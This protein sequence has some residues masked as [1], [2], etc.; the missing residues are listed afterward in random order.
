[1]EEVMSEEKKQEPE[2]PAEESDR[3][4]TPRHPDKP[5]PP[6]DNDAGIDITFRKGW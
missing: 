3:Q 4:K 2:K 6:M 1:M 5:R